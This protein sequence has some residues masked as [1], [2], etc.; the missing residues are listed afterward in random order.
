MNVPGPVT[1]YGLLTT[2]P[3]QAGKLYPAR[4]VPASARPAPL[5]VKQ[6]RPPATVPWKGG[7]IAVTDFLARTH[8]ASFL[9]VH[10]GAITYEWY[11]KGVRPTDRTASWSV[12]KSLVSLMVGQAIADRKLSEDDK[13]VALLPELR[14]GGTSFDDVTVRHLLDMT[15]GI[16]VSENYSQA[17]PFTGTARMYL[18][19][20]L[21]GFVKDHRGMETEPGAAASYRSVDT[22]LLGLILARVEGKPL[23]ALLSE[24]L[25]NPVGAQDAAT[26]NLDHGGGA[27][28]AFCCVNATPRDFA[29][30]GQLVLDGGR[31]IVP[32]AWIKRISTPAPKEVDGWKYSAQ[33]WRPSADAISALGVYGQY[34]YVHPASKTV[35]VKFSDHGTEQ[36]ERETFAALRAVATGATGAT[37]SG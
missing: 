13:V 23:A 18:T 12:A 36:D 24:R 20:D 3:S 21:P 25:W 30:I 28:K 26:W 14:T 5:P 29:K 37:G 7:R 32:A 33:W 16:G 27:E 17:W 10:D 4:T 11:R 34:V 22:E 1:L 8:T 19:K 6:G 35:I 9:V 2:A 15:A 31:G